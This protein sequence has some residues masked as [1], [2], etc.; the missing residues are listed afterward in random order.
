MSPLEA[1]TTTSLAAGLLLIVPLGATEQHGP[2]LPLG[3]DTVIALA[4]S[5]ALADRL[6]PALAALAPALPYGA[7]GE[8]Q[9]FDGTLSIGTE[10]LTAVLV[11]LARSATPPGGGPFA[12]VLFVSGHGG[13]ADALRRGV[14]ALR[15]EGRSVSGWFP[16]L[17][18]ADAHAGRTETSLMLH[19]RPELVRLDRA[20]PGIVEPLA[21]LLPRLR[22]VGMRG[23]SPNGV[24]GDP[25]GASAGEGKR[26]FDALVDDLTAAARAFRAA[27]PM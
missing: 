26:I 3:T 20:E 24:L 7:S 13:N 12:A 25:T 22:V 4:L 23:V 1:E 18:G 19:L 21:D 17:Q 8:H 16:R 27:Q 5:A 10:A 14:A 15:A 2:H 6:G 9:G 11:E